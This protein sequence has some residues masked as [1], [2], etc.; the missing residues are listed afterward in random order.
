MD[1]S[2]VTFT[3]GRAFYLHKTLKAIKSQAENYQGKIYHH[4]FFQGVGISDET[5]HVLYEDC[6]DNYF[7]I[8][9]E[10]EHNVGIAE[11]TNRA[12][13]EIKTDYM[14]KI[15]DDI[16]LISDNFFKH[17]EEIISFEPNAFIAPFPIG[18][19]T[20]CGGPKPISYKVEYSKNTDTYYTFR[21]V[22]VTGGGC[23]L[24]P[25][26][27]LKGLLPL[28]N[29]LAHGASGSDDDQ[30]T[31]LCNQHG[32]P[33]YYIENAIAFE[34][35]ESCLGQRERFREYYQSRIDSKIIYPY[36]KTLQI[37]LHLRELIK[38]LGFGFI[39]NGFD[40]LKGRSMHR[41]WMH[42]I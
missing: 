37:K 23:R 12:I 5:K 24:I 19:I 29:D 39:L 1:F 15:D 17:I 25:T 30:L 36:A 34:H 35:Q 27:I 10:W 2:I 7:P 33:I 4:L 28:E 26:E 20:W 14:F 42:R 6:S 11:G 3:L 13:A 16:L 9:H 32:I 18:L 38:L 31:V 8:V 40:R 22:N 41:G 21:K